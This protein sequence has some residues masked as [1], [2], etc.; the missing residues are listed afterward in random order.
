MIRSLT[1]RLTGAAGVTAGA[2]ALAAFALA[3]AQALTSSTFIGNFSKLKTIAS[4]VPANGDQN[5]YGVAVV[6]KSEGKLVKGDILVSNFNNTSNFQGTGTTIVQISPGGHRSVFALIDASKLPGPCPGGVGL[7]TALVILPGG[8]VVVGS[9]PTTDGK[10]DTANDGCLIVIGKDGKVAET[11]SNGQIK[12]PWDMTA[13]SGGGFADLF[14]TNVLNGTLAAGG[15]TVDKGTVLRLTLQLNGDMPPTLVQTTKIGSGFG[16]HTDP[17]ALVVGPTGVGL[18]DDG[19]LYVADSVGNRITA[20]PNAI[21]RG[22]DAGTGNVVTSGGRLN[23][24]LGLVIAPNDDILTVN[25]A[26]GFIV[27]TTPGGKQVAHHLLNS[28][29]TPKGNGALFGLAVT[30]DHD[31]VY[32][33]DD[34]VNQLRL[35]H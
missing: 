27:E 11:L 18:G 5:P 30:P 22:G 6:G 2:A 21:K 25:A 35:F 32:F 14:V 26:D 4:T 16:E 13:A 23:T 17:T 7:T 9:L 12:G 33:V 15:A 19:T 1:R 8:W 31:G 10:S 20:I 28:T 3:P 24:P 34:D 29:G